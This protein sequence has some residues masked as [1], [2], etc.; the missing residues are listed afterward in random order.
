MPRTW[1]TKVWKVV[2]F[3]TT[4]AAAATF[5]TIQF[6]NGRMKPN[7]SIT[8]KWSEKPLLKS[9]EKT[10]PTLGWP[11]TT[12]SLCPGCV[13]EAREAI[14]K[15]EKDWRDLV[16]EKVGEIKAQ[17]VERDGQVWMVKDCPIHGRCEDLMAVDSKFLEWIEE[18]FPGRDIPAHSDEDLH[19]H[20]SRAE[21]Y[22]S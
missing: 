12:D 22:V 19:R 3:A 15:G 5:H 9:W 14:L 7:P 8:P 17:I 16:H 21:H 4:Q 11:R 2:D 1:G 10:K 13:K 6:F 20:G 18:N